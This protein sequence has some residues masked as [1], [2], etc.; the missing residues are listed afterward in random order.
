[1]FQKPTYAGLEQRVKDLEESKKKFPASLVDNSP[2]FF[3]AIDA[4]GKTITMNQH[5]LKTLGYTIYEV[6][7]KNY[8]STFVPERDRELLAAVFRKLTAGHEHTL[9]ENYIVSKD[10]KEFLVEWHGTP[11]FDTNGTFRFFYGFG[12]DITQRKQ[13]EAEL[14]KYKHIVSSSSDHLAL[15]DKNYVYQMVNDA[16]LKAQN[17]KIEDIVGHSV[18]ELFGQEFFEKNQKPHIDRCLNGETVQYKLWVRIPASGRRYMEV[19]HYPYYEEDGSISGYVVNARDV[20]DRKRA[21]EALEKSEKKFRD[22][23]DNV[24]DFLYQHDLEGNFVETN[25]AFKKEFGMEGDTLTYPNLQDM[26]TERNKE[27]F[28]DYLKRIIANGKDEGLLDI[29]TKEGRERV[30]EYKN[31]LVYDSKG[32]PTGVQGSGR[33]ITE[34]LQS[35]IE[36]KKMEQQLQQ[37]QKMEAIGTLAGGISHNFRNILTIISL[38]C[39][40]FQE[41]NKGDAELA[42]I[43][44]SMLS[45]VDRGNKL[46]NQLLEFSSEKPKKEFQPLNLSEMLREI[47]QF[48][49][50]AYDKS[51][52]IR[53]SIPDLMSIDGD[54][55]E[56]SQVFLNLCSNARDAMPNGGTLKIEAEIVENQ[57]SVVI[58]DTGVGMD[59]ET[60]EKCFEPFFTTKPIDKGTGLGLSTAYGTVKKHGGDIAVHS[61]LGYGTAFEIYFPLTCKDAKAKKENLDR[62]NLV[63]NKKILI[64]DDEIE[65]CKLIKTLLIKLGYRVQYVDSGKAAINKYRSWK[66]DVVLLDRS[67]P[68]MDGISCAEK[69]VNYDSHAKILIMSG[70]DEDGLTGIAKHQKELIKGYL[71]KPIHI[72]KLNA[73]LL[74]LLQT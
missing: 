23:F 20:T 14:H 72:K 35:A 74:N 68:G 2:I 59:Q 22:I 61:K 5:M 16:Y 19:V 44:D 56:L 3:V 65:I 36:K 43:I 47:H 66:P 45:Y 62:V 27:K 38:N 28:D 11:V 64:V 67:M 46:V 40:I 31:F 7:E 70:Y 1:M 52:D 26:I 24:S 21:E 39:Q 50:F 41:K 51:I 69:I 58:S 33:D 29:R 17:K 60:L 6:T 57:A 73:H 4:Q 48:I 55:A 25:F 15:L 32:I 13:A 30:V 63:K 54:H 12:I 9:N 53:L 42:A 71:T 37:A 10:G 34:R 18:P 8:L 49:K